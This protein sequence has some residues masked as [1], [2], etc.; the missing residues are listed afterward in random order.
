MNPRTKSL[1][2]SFA[3]GGA[4]SLVIAYFVK[5]DLESE[6]GRGAQELQAHLE[7]SGSA[8]RAQITAEATAAGRN[9]ALKALNDYGITPTLVAQVQA[10]ARLA[11]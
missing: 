10:L 4:V 8:L 6:F 5:R 7:D 1:V 3:A 11:G 9:A 2:L